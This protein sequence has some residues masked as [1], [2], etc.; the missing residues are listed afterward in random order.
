M[1]TL[2]EKW[3]EY[4]FVIPTTKD[5][6]DL[7]D[8]WMEIAKAAFYAGAEAALDA[9]ETVDINAMYDE[10]AAFKKCTR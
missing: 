3:E 7:C 2:S 4:D 6:E 1:S 9:E 5:R 8:A 10:I